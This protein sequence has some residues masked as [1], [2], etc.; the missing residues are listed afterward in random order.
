MKKSKST[1]PVMLGLIEELLRKSRE[2]DA[3]IWRELVKR[4]TKSSKN[5]A[6]VNISTIARHTKNK[7]VIAVPGKVLGDGE[8]NH[9]VTAAA[10]NFTAQAR[11]KITAKGGKCLSLKEL[12]KA[13]PKGSGIRIMG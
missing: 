1:N 12:I 4:L 6:E 5:K 13:H 8:I 11:E 2:E 9:K 7:D 3:R 10:L